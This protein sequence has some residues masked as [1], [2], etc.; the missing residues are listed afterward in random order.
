M[1]DVLILDLGYGN[2]RSVALAFERLGARTILSADPAAVDRADRRLLLFRLRVPAR[3][4]IGCG[5]AGSIASFA[6]A[7]A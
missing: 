3:Q 5:K 2:T 6:T 4:W 1:S 7:P